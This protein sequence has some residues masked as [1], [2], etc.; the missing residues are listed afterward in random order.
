MKK[1]QLHNSPELTFII[2]YCDL[3]PQVPVTEAQ[4]AEKYCHVRKNL[5]KSSMLHVL[6]GVSVSMRN[7]TESFRK[8]QETL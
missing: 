2:T 4:T 7:L 6:T 1:L 8:S 3:H 5:L